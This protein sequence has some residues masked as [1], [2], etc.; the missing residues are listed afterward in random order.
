[1]RDYEHVC[2][3]VREKLLCIGLLTQKIKKLLIGQKGP[4]HTYISLTQCPTHKH[5]N[6]YIISFVSYVGL[7]DFHHFNNMIK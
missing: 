1:M 2:H 5:I 7:M 6:S 3:I 4:S